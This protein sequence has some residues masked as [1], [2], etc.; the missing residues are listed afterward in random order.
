M[1]SNA[2]SAAEQSSGQAEGIIDVF[3]LNYDANYF[4]WEIG[5]VIF[6]P[7]YNDWGDVVEYFERCE[8][9]ATQ[10][11]ERSKMFSLAASKQEEFFKKIDDIKNTLR[12][13]G[14]HHT[15]IGIIS[16]VWDELVMGN[17]LSSRQCQQGLKGLEKAGFP[18]GYLKSQARGLE[19]PL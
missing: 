5:T 7:K 3:C 10:P 6:G 13:S 16:D 18:T 4:G 8:D 2:A 11:K 12:K 19:I 15:N 1:T 9:P 14:Y 17:F